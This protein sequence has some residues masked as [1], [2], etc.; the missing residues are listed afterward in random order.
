MEFS[1][2]LG[3]EEEFLL[4]E[5][6]KYKKSVAAIYGPLLGA[7]IAEG[8]TEEE[9]ATNELLSLEI[10]RSQ[11]PAD[12]WKSKIVKAVFSQDVISDV[13]MPR[14]LFDV[15]WRGPERLA[16]ARMKIINIVGRK[17]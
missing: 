1:Y 5:E 6:E 10:V 9:V 12:V 11:L 7:G 2:E 15:V 17:I 16:D 8:W 14:V 4:E 13:R 3:E